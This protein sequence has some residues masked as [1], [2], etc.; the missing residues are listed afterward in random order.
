MTLRQ[1]NKEILNFVFKNGQH[2]NTS[3]NQNERF[4]SLGSV[5]EFCNSTNTELP[6]ELK[7][8]TGLGLVYTY[9]QNRRFCTV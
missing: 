9:R 7:V 4:V 6:W 2:K 3:T 8:N 1:T 5:G